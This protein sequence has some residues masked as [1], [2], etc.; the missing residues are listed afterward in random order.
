MSDQVKM[1]AMNYAIDRPAA[2]NRLDALLVGRLPIPP[3]GPGPRVER[4]DRP[5]RP[6]RSGR[7]DGHT[8]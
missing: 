2:E 5:P 1:T 3:R 7:I 6:G 4:D 8:Q